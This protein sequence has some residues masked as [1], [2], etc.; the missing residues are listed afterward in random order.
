MPLGGAPLSRRLH[1]RDPRGC[2]RGLVDLPRSDVMIA[3][4]ASRLAR[5]AR[6]AMASGATAPTQAM[7]EFRSRHDG[8]QQRPSDRRCSVLRSRRD[9]TRVRVRSRR[10][11]RR[12]IQRDVQRD[13]HGRQHR[14]RPRPRGGRGGGR[15]L[16]HPDHRGARGQREGGR[17]RPLRDSRHASPG[18][19]R[20]RLRKSPRVPPVG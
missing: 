18:T 5:A 15:L 9:S 12:A 20:V 3:R 1:S 8:E 17:P 2:A 11:G 14:H 4:G 16:L 7:P 10:A 19:R 13:G 6:S